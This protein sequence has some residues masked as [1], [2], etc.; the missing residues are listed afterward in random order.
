MMN[1]SFHGNLSLFNIYLQLWAH[2]VVWSKQGSVIGRRRCR[3]R[4]FFS[5]KMHQQLSGRSFSW[6]GKRKVKSFL[7]FSSG[8]PHTR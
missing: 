3:S 8:S 5:R 1:I 6:W 4:L 2:E 7:I